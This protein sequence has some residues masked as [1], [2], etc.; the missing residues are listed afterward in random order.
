MNEVRPP[1]QAKHDLDIHNALVALR[2]AAQR[3]REHAARAG[4]TVVIFRD[5]QITEELPKEQDKNG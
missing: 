4:N 5:G 3:A 2:R 1:E